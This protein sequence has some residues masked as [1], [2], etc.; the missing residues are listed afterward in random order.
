MAD[1]LSG[2]PSAAECWT[3]T[4]GQKVRRIGILTGGGDCPGLNAVIRAVTKKAIFEHGLE[5]WGIEDAFLG[6]IENRAHPLTA[7]DASNILTQGGTILGTTNKVDPAHYRTGTDADGNPVYEDVTPRV[8]ENV[9]EWGLDVLV[10]IGGD[11]TMTGVQ[12]LIDHGLACVG[13]PKT[14]DNDLAHTDVTFGFQT[15]VD[16]ATEALDRVHTT[17]ASHHRV[18]LVEMMG[19]NAGWLTLHA[20]LA[21]GADVILIPEIP[22]DVQVVADYC[23]MRGRFGKAFTIVAVSE[24][25]KPCGGDVVVKN[26]DQD[27]PDPIRLGGVS[28]VLRVQ[29]EQMTGLECRATILGHVQRGGS[30]CAFD[31]VLATRYGCAAVDLVVGGDW[32]RVVVIEGAKL[33]SVPV[34]AVAGRQRQVPL[35]HPL[36]AAARALGTCMGDATAA[37]F[38]TR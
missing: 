3:M 25:A 30:P 37:C 24:G 23:K 28:Q 9:R 21:G 33:T 17:A 16:I 1:G 15:A 5:V 8:V 38:T 31:R 7:G 11:G 19:R 26:I 29:L 22:Y 34:S 10:C 32:N 35:D 20:G 12:N 13:V 18:M 4:A 14:I 6:L 27:S 2:K 36:I